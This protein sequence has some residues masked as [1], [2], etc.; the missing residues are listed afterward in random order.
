M[1]VVPRRLKGFQD[2]TPELMALRLMII[3]VAREVA[4]K[5]GFSEIGTPALEY[6]EVLLGVGGETDK[7]VFRFLDGGE[8]DVALRYDLTIPF[9]RYAAE[10][11]GKILFPFKRL[12]IGDVWRAEKP[13]K[14]RYREFCQCDIDIIGVDS[15]NADVEILLSAHE[16]LSNILDRPFTI[17]CN[18][19]KILSFFI[20]KFLG[21]SGG[22]QEEQALII[23]DKIEKIGPENIIND[24]FLK[25]NVAHNRSEKLLTTLNEVKGQDP[26][27]ITDLFDEP[28]IKSHWLR[29][30]ETIKIVQELTNNHGK[31]VIDLSIARGL[32]YYTGIVYETT[33][34]DIVGFGSIC[35]GG[36][37]DN[38]AERF[39]NQPMPGVGISIGVD[40]LAALLFEHSD[41]KEM[42]VPK[43]FI[44]IAEEGITDDAFKLAKKLRDFGVTTDIALKEQKLG[45]Q[46]K[47][48]DK[49]GFAYVLPLGSHELLQGLFT[50][51]NMKTGE[52]H[53][54]LD[55]NELTNLILS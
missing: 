40:R 27:V 28:A 15:R 43:V 47:Y 32:A 9:A 21:I 3:N 14:G 48:A 35:S 42:G 53:R 46:F 6:A 20:H 33:V 54:G 50:L 31:V 10:N 36:R 2:Y 5:A 38:L 12:Q 26:S 22:E 7:Q 51:K 11:S 25:L 19:R 8:R 23:L 13:Q 1:K 24:L 4:R 45:A 34:D 16:M 29:F 52:E 17:S 37:Y 18:N 30:L 44:A 41:K 55:F 39:I 49:R